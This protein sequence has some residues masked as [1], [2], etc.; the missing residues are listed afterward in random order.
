MTGFS[1]SQINLKIQYTYWLFKEPEC[2]SYCFNQPSNQL[3]NQW[4]WWLKQPNRMRHWAKVS[5]PLGIP[6]G[7]QST[8]Y[9]SLG[10]PPY[11]SPGPLSVQWQKFWCHT[12]PCISQQRHDL[13]CTAVT[14]PPVQQNCSVV[15]CLTQSQD[16]GLSCS[17]GTGSMGGKGPPNWLSQ[18]PC[19]SQKFQ[20][21]YTK[22]SSS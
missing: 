21:Y 12:C 20:S 7:V 4:L 11:S 6:R 3:S 16:W 22:F 10:L 13:H 2:G 14:T 19:G 9:W 18:L 17:R 5:H 8:T 1:K 15:L